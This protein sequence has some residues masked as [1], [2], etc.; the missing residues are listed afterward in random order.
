MLAKNKHKELYLIFHLPFL[1]WLFEIKIEQHE[2]VTNDVVNR[3][4]VR[5]STRQGVTS[6][7]KP[8]RI[9]LSRD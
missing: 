2:M 8:W 1:I 3:N 7:R 5:M 6:E 4:S 9:W